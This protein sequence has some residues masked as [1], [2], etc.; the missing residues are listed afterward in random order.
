VSSIRLIY[1]TYH[2]RAMRSLAVL[3]LALSVAAVGAIYPEDH[4]T[5]R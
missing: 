3:V 4:W 1:C 2:S 5:Y